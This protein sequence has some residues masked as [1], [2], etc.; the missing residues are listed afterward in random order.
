MSNASA[1]ATSSITPSISTP[2]TSTF[3]PPINLKNNNPNTPNDK[4]DASSSNLLTS[5]LRAQISQ[6]QKEKNQAILE[7]NRAE[8]KLKL[9]TEIKQ[10]GELKTYVKDEES[11]FLNLPVKID[12]NVSLTT[13]NTCLI[14][15]KIHIDGAGFLKFL[16]S[17]QSSN[18][19]YHKRLSSNKEGSIVYYSFLV[20]SSKNVSSP[21]KS[22]SLIL[23]LKVVRDDKDE[24]RIEIS[25]LDSEGKTRFSFLNIFK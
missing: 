19:L 12:D 4:Q 25:S 6:L 20:D 22:I 21:D 5:A 15:S 2:V 18:S 13:T 23:N 17:D 9:L 16:T 10:A 3:S 14:K 8:L 7:K 1:N 11:T 24:I